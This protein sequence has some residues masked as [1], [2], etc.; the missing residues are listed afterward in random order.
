MCTSPALALGRAPGA[1]LALTRPPLSALLGFEEFPSPGRSGPGFSCSVCPWEGCGAGRRRGGAGGP[2][3]SADAES[4]Q[5]SSVAGEK[6]R[7]SH[8]KS[9]ISRSLD[10]YN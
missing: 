4:V 2:D 9:T 3:D 10:N 7:I 8:E 6:K 5:A 1:A